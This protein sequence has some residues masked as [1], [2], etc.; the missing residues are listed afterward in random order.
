MRI[1]S[2]TKRGMLLKAPDGTDTRPTSDRTRESLFNILAPYVADS[3]FLDLFSGSGAVG[4]EALS[5]GA[6]SV[7]FAENSSCGI[8]EYNL[9]KSGFTENSKI[10]KC[11][12]F[13]FLNTVSKKF[14]LIFLDPPY[15]KG[16]IEK[17]LEIIGRRGILKET[18]IAVAECDFDENIASE[19]SG[20]KLFDRRKYGRAVLN[21]YKY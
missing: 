20:L 15:H 19:I 9:K 5:R 10:F 4:T 2:G 1:I 11:D 13:S 21:F 6:K 7:Y 14:D 12:V 18:G 16:Y 8:I 3:D 17:S